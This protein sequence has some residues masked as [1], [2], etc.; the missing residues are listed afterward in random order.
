MYSGRLM[1]YHTAKYFINKL[2]VGL[3]PSQHN[4]KTNLKL[5]KPLTS[6]VL[7][8]E[9]RLILLK[10]EKTLMKKLKNPSPKSIM[11]VY[12]KYY[13][14]LPNLDS[15]EDF[16]ECIEDIHLLIDI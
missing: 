9:T 1:Q 10:E 16:T 12:F 5:L 7:K 4:I 11:N 2:L 15:T 8:N 14:Y 13:K 3:N 6:V